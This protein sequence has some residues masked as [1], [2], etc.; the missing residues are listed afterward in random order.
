MMNGIGKKVAMVMIAAL[1]AFAM[2]GAAAAQ[3]DP[4]AAQEVL[5]GWYQ[6]ML[7]LVRHTPTY[8]PPVAARTFAYLGVT[9]FEAVASGSGELQSL[10]GQLNGL[11]GVPQRAAGETYDEAVVHP[12]RD[13]VSR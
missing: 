11:A 5:R 4:P 8:S 13:G 2:P 3:G 1:A 7:E 10:A 6:L 9:A 12:G